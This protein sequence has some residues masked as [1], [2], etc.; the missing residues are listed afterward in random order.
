MARNASKPTKS[1]LEIL[2]VLWKK[3]PST[4]RQVHD[5]LSGEAGYTTTLKFMQIMVEK[6]LLARD[7]NSRSHVYRPAVPQ[8]KTQKHLVSELVQKAFAGSVHKLM[9]AALSGQRASSEELGEMRKLIDRL[10]TQQRDT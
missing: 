4:V 5:E 9:I 3:G 10:E 6:G 1:E 8:E 2:A 7:E